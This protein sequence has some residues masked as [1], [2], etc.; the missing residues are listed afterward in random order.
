MSR[1]VWCCL[2]LGLV[3]SSC[4]REL[5]D[6][7]R[8][9]VIDD[10]GFEYFSARAKIVYEDG[11]QRL[12]AIA[13]IRMRK[14]SIIWM[15]VSKLGVEGARLKVDRDSI[16]ILDRLK[17]RYSARSLKQLSTDLDFDVDY[18]MIESVVLG[19]LIYPYTKE[20][21][22]NQGNYLQ[23]YQ[24]LENFLFN[25]YIG[26]STK[27]LEKLTVEDTAS[28]NTISV[29]YGNFKEV[30]SEIFPFSIAALIKYAKESK[31]DITLNI[32]FSKAEIKEGPLS[33][34]FST[35]SKY[36]RI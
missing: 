9:L 12:N 11:N 30:E 7:K 2:V 33:F 17:K 16:Y 31:D 14:D 23:Y 6:F 34:P 22:D 4:K 8:D 24:Q 19:N 13:N 29:N 35:P 28:K 32:G 36:K 3:L 18:A 20:E 1:V 15:S 21:L 26:K 5:V 25:N 27:K 10:F